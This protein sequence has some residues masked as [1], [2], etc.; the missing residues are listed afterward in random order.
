MKCANY[1]D[2]FN[3]CKVSGKD[4]NGGEDINCNFHTNEGNENEQ[5]LNKLEAIIMEF[6][7]ENGGYSNG[8]FT[9]VE[10]IVRENEIH[11]LSWETPESK[12]LT[13]EEIQ[14]KGFELNNKLRD[15]VEFFK[16]GEAKIVA[17]DKDFGVYNTVVS[18]VAKR[19]VYIPYKK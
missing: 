8:Y 12:K 15:V 1:I 17:D 3:I 18:Y 16:I 4:C 14:F 19:R 11:S 9:F 5:I 13:A 10:G 2:D 7:L 6:L